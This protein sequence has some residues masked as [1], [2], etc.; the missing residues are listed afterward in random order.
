MNIDAEYKIRKLEQSTHMSVE[1]LICSEC[2]LSG[3]SKMKVFLHCL[4]SWLTVSP[5]PLFPN[6]GLSDKT[7]LLFACSTSCCNTDIPISC[8]GCTQYRH[9]VSRSSSSLPERQWLWAHRSSHLCVHTHTIYT[10]ATKTCA[11][12]FVAA[13][14]IITQTWKQPTCP[15][16]SEWI[17]KLCYIQTMEYYAALN[18]MRY[19]AIKRPGRKLNA[20]Y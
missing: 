3:R 18:K 11:P 8:L 6:E 10:Y 12:M 4:G 2:L 17:N 5:L 20:F 16:T 15:S 7:W 9:L 13:S 19:Q 14:L 1:K